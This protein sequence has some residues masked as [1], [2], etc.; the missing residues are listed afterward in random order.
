[1][2]RPRIITTEAMDLFRE[3]AVRRAQ[4][5]TNKQLARLFD[6]KVTE[7][8]VG[9]VV[10]RLRREY[11][12][13]TGASV[14]IPTQTDMRRVMREYASWRAMLSRCQNANHPSYFR[15]GGRGISVCE[16]W[17]KFE[18]FLA[19]MGERPRGKTLDRY[20]DNNG[21]YEP[22]NCRW[23]TPSEQSSNRRAR[24]VTETSTHP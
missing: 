18:N 9:Q 12:R 22:G 14:H 2:S 10:A 23:A 15:Y 16:R 4:S 17:L 1:M 11:E 8:Y 24:V 19:D 20:P 13:T 7:K 6:D 5:R 3:E 21:N